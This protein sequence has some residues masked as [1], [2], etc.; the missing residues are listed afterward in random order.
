MPFM[1]KT[2]TLLDKP[3]PE[4]GVSVG[5]T[6][7]VGEKVDIVEEGGGWVKVK[8]IGLFGEGWTLSD[9]VGDTSPIPPTDTIDDEDL[10]AFN[11]LCWLKGL[12][13]N[14]TPHYL[15]AIAK[16]RCG[17]K[18]NN[19][20]K[21]GVTGPFRLSEAEWDAARADPGLGF[22]G[23]VLG[24]DI[25]DWTLQCGV[26]AAMAGRDLAAL[27]TEIKT[28]P[29]AA[30]LYLAQLIGVKAA[31][32]AIGGAALIEDAFKNGV[33][34]PPGGLTSEQLIAKYSKYFPA[35]GKT[36]CVDALELIAVDL[37][38]ALSAEKQAVID[39]GT[40]VLGVDPPTEDMISNPKQKIPDASDLQGGA[41][42]DGISGAGGPLGSLI[43]RGEGGYDSFNRGRAGDSR[44]AHNPAFAAM[45]IGQIVTEQSRPPGDPTR[46]FAVGKYQVI[47]V[48]MRGAVAALGLST[49][50][51]Y[52]HEVQELVF[53]E[54]LIGKKR[55]K[56]KS[57]V[58]GGGASLQAAQFAL[59]L[60][61]ASV[62]DPTKGGR[63]HYGGS[64]GNRASITLAQTAAALQQERD[65]YNGFIAGGLSPAAA[66]TKLSE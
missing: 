60:E 41:G 42:A 36:K 10:K 34:L 25:R 15:L 55:P 9:T 57:F 33:P 31:G 17:D 54:Y 5:A 63:S 21:D 43:S 7:N 35:A 52:T 22:K 45:T 2:R 61:F 23:I 28:Q 47:P 64:G 26:F 48:T 58:T 13:Y 14:I 62:G 6:P 12:A 44:G 40:E 53:R 16:L 32:K 27:K 4:G 56:V 66:W 20:T 51:K 11:R 3:L 59:A 49:S 65:R 29:S 46:L 37:D 50:Q 1:Q 24:S 30:Q 8:R 18:I 38:Q 39:A 19:A